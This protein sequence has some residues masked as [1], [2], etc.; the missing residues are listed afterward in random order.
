MTRSDALFAAAARWELRQ[1]WSILATS[2]VMRRLRHWDGRVMNSLS[3][4]LWCLKHAKRCRA[5]ALVA[6]REVARQERLA[7]YRADMR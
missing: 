5:L 2:G 7:R 4:K 3:V 1:D 6:M